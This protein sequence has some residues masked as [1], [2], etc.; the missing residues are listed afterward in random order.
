MPFLD[1]SLHRF[2]DGLDTVTTKVANNIRQ[3]FLEFR[4]RQESIQE[5]IKGRASHMNQL[6]RQIGQR[7]HNLSDTLHL[8]EFKRGIVRDLALDQ[9]CHGHERHIFSHHFTRVNIALRQVQ[10]GGPTRRLVRET[11][12]S[13]DRVGQCRLSRRGIHITHD[14]LITCM[15]AMYMIDKSN[16]I[17]IDI[18]R[19]S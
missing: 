12:R 18:E 14:S 3:L 8:I 16:N 13:N 6:G 9:G 11:T 2:L 5:R 4:I 7:P 10:L 15:Y 19:K 1:Y 17:S